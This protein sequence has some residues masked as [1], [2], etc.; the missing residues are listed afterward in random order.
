MGA[1]AA[2]AWASMTQSTPSKRAMPIIPAI[3]RRL[4][5]KL[6][7]KTNASAVIDLKVENAEQRGVDTGRHESRINDTLSR[8]DP[9]SAPD[10]APAPQLGA[11]ACFRP[12]A[13]G[14]II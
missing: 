7:H 5:T 14:N 3:P 9:E 2:F 10:D 8:V 12:R 13:G 1:A 11:A 6:L 4:E